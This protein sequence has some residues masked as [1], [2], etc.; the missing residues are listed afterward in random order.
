[1]IITATMIGI[2]YVLKAANI[3]TPKKSL[4]AMDIMKPSGGTE[5]GVLIKCYAVYKK[6]I[7]K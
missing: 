5:A 3:K 6:W 1:M 7:N 4:H 2:F